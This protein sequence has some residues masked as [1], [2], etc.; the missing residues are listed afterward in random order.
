MLE[1]QEFVSL[2]QL[3]KKVISSFF[4]L[5]ARQIFLR[6]LSFI[7][8]NIILAKVLPVE[9][10]GI[11]NIATSIITFFAFFSDVGLAASLIQ[12]KEEVK[13]EDIVTTFTIQTVIVGFLSL[14]IILIAPLLGEFYKLN[15]DGVWLIRILGLGFLLTSLKVVPSVLME[16]RLNFKPIITVEL[17]ETLIFNTLLITLTFQNFGIWAFSLAVLARS[18]MGVFLIYILVPVKI[19]LGIEKEAAKKLLSFGVPFQLN[20]L[21][22]V[23]KDRLVPLVVANMVGPSGV[24]YITWAQNMALLPL[25]FMNIVIRIVFPAFSRLQDNK[26]VLSKAVEKALFT[27]ALVVFPVLFGIGAILPS[28]ISQVVT[29]KWQPA[30]ISFYLFAFAT[31]WAVISTTLTNTLNAVGQVRTTLKLMVMWTALEWILTPTIVYFYGFQGVGISS[32][33]IS[34]SSAITIILVKRILPV[35][36]LEAITI[37]TFCSLF[38]GLSVF[39]LSNLFVRSKLELFGVILA[40]VLIYLGTIFLFA[41]ER[42]SADLKTLRNG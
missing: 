24:G 40:G 41:K 34:F 19:G 32:F 13:K 28:L 9:T 14:I 21:L 8:L 3:K 25:E 6:A 29:S 1:N 20:S 11:F 27:I 31:Y 30:L 22:A 39:L 5:T 23:L 12:K 16:R 38:M 33:L 36:I 10:L 26:Q 4:S 18:I 15:Q 37:P 7:T 42:I 2:S 17:I 35:K